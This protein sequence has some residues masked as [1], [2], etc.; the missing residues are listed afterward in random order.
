MP[1]KRIGV[2]WLPIGSARPH[3]AQWHTSSRAIVLPSSGRAAS[4]RYQ[5]ETWR[6]APGRPS[7][8]TNAERAKRRNRQQ[9][10]RGTMPPKTKR[11]GRHVGDGTRK[12]EQVAAH[13]R[14]RMRKQ[15]PA[16]GQKQG[17]KKAKKTAARARHDEVRAIMAAA[18]LLDQ[19]RRNAK[20]ELTAEEWREIDRQR[21]ERERAAARERDEVWARV[22][23]HAARTATASAPGGP[24]PPPAPSR[25]CRPARLLPPV[26]PVPGLM[27]TFIAPPPRR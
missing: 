4:N 25:V 10:I 15:Q 11:Q 8:E 20:R 23:Q 19:G 21:S 6:P 16:A 22:L 24:P 18:R 2:R 26:R 17:H 5:A 1:K 14:D 27:P 3:R 9:A 7:E 12:T 13:G